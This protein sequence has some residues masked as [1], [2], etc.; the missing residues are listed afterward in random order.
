MK[1]TPNPVLDRLIIDHLAKKY[2]LKEKREGIHLS[3]LVYCLTRSFYDL[4]MPIE[5]TDEELMLWALG[6]GLQE[7]LTP[8]E[9]TTPTFEEEGIV[10]RPDMVFEMEG[11][12]LELKTTRASL[13]KNLLN[14][15]ETWVEYIMGGCHIR[16]IKSYELSGLYLMGNYAPPFPQIYSETL[17]F[18][19]TEL[20]E[21]WERI[22]LRRS[23]YQAAIDRDTPP[24]PYR[25]NKEW[26]CN[27]CR[28]ST[29]C[30][31]V[32]GLTVR[33]GGR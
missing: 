30:S 13:K 15:P 2:K 25:W 18:N 27:N 5:P 22:L 3:T 19:K 10:Y 29:V 11:F 20:D 4:T 26:E 17:S 16:K 14:L 31:A 21:N 7:V 1:R 6:Y 23:A 9:A 24:T 8:A 12:T 33:Q 32:E 28:Y